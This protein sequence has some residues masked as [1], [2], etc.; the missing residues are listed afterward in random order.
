MIVIAVDVDILK[1]GLGQVI[2]FEGSIQILCASTVKNMD[3]NVTRNVKDFKASEIKVLSPDEF[4][5]YF[6]IVHIIKVD[7]RKGNTG[8]SCSFIQL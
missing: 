5:M 1:K 6:S 2:D 3:C 7:R 4:S 8:I